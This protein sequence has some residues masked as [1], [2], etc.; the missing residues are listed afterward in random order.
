LIETPLQVG[1]IRTTPEPEATLHQ[2]LSEIPMRR[3]GQATEVARVACFLVS[4][5]SSYMTG[6]AIVV[7][8]GYIAR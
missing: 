6:E 7:D 2:R 5:D 3:L 4:D 8:G 1:R